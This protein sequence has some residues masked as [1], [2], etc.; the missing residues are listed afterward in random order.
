VRNRGSCASNAYNGHHEILEDR[1]PAS[2]PG[3]VLDEDYVA[4]RQQSDS[5]PAATSA[6]PAKMIMN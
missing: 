6:E 4:S 5:P 3:R 1:A 2:R